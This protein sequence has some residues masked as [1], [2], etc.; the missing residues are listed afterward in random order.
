MAEALNTDINSYQTFNEFFT[1]ALKP[2]CR[3]VANDKQGLVSP[4]DGLVS[5]AGRIIEGCLIQAKGFSYSAQEL[6]GGDSAL[7]ETFNNGLYTTIYLSPKDYHRL[8]MPMTGTLTEM[9]HVP[10]RLFSVNTATSNTVP[11]LY[12]R[13]ERVCCIFDTEFGTMALVLVG[14]MIV[15]SIETIL[16]WRCNTANALYCSAL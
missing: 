6:L 5:Q 11:G 15:N 12:A 16:A 13:N 9:I 10:G 8:H 3:P 4:A 14:A 1:R 2:D 7:A